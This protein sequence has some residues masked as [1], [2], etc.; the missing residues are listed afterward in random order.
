MKGEVIG[1]TTAKSTGDAVESI[2]FAIPIN[3]VKQMI[4]ELMENGHISAPYMG[5]EV[6]N[7]RDGMGVYVN[8]VEPGSPADKAG[9]KKGD[10]ILAIGEYETISLSA[11]DKALRNFEPDQTTTIQIYRSRQVLEL[12]ITF[13]SKY[14]AAS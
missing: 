5:I 8:S 9:L 3:D 7:E 11:L 14:P 6:T 1:I 13:G 10:L 12:T 4:T 2:G